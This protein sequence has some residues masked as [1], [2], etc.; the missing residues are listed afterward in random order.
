MEAETSLDNQPPLLFLTTFPKLPCKHSLEIGMHLEAILPSTLQSV[1]TAVV[2]DIIDETYFEI[3]INDYRWVTSL[4]NPLLLPCDFCKDHLLDLI[5][6]GEDTKD[7]IWEEYLSSVGGKR[8]PFDLFPERMFGTDLGFEEGHKIEALSPFDPCKIG[9]ATIERIVGHLLL[10][11]LDANPTDLFYRSATSMDIFPVEWTH[12]NGLTL[13]IPSSFAPGEKDS[14]TEQ[15]FKY[16]FLQRLFF[17]YLQK[18][19]GT[20]SQKTN[21]QLH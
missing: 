4:D 19:L 1:H 20:G 14:S 21:Q 2:S 13:A 18:G 16:C 10:L 11:K 7:F 17:W 5:H 3:S 12:A 6:P 8:V 9:I 15:V